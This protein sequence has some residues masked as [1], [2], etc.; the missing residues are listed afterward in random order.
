LLLLLS[1]KVSIIFGTNLFLFNFS[2]KVEFFTDVSFDPELLVLNDSLFPSI[3]IREY[4]ENYDDCWAAR[5]E[6][7]S[8]QFVLTQL[9]FREKNILLPFPLRPPNLQ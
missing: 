1:V 8:L 9:Q 3:K 6:Q 4:R 7:I 2:D 5:F